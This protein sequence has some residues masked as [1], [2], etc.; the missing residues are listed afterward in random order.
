MNVPLVRPVPKENV[1]VSVENN[2]NNE[3]FKNLN[4][5]LWKKIK[6]ANLDGTC[7]EYTDCVDPLVCLNSTCQSKWIIFSRY[8]IL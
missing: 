1:F 6:I 7:Q 5:I 4:N 2:K 3:N 8:K